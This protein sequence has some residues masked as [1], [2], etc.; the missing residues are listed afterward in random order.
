MLGRP[1]VARDVIEA[2][3]LDRELRRRF[4]R[5]VEDAARDAAADPPH[6]DAGKRTDL[7]DLPTFTIDPPSARDFD[8]AISAQV[9]DDVTRV[10]VHIADVTAHVLPGSP[11][12]REAMRRATS[13]YV[14]GAVEPML[15]EAL[16]NFACS[17]VPGEDRLAVTVEIDFRGA[18]RV[19][20]AFYR[21]VIR[22][23]KRLTYPQVDAIFAGEQRAEGRW[24]Q[25]LAAAR[26]VAQALDDR[27]QESRGALEILSGEPDFELDPR[28]HV[29]GQKQ[30]P[31]TESHRLV[32]HLMIA[33]NESVAT[34]LESQKRPT[35]YR[36][37]EAP[38]PARIE[39]L[40]K[41]LAS[42]DV[43]TPPLRELMTTAAGGRGG[44]GDL[45]PGRGARRADRAR[46]GG[47]RLAGA[48]L[49]QAGGVHA[50]QPRPRRSRVAALPALHLA[51]PPLSRR[52][53]APRAA[54][55]GRWR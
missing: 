14:P 45:A 17:L 50:G 1:D 52:R 32:E 49:A 43:P 11:V 51:D 5:L 3:M 20:T 29:I 48:A 27:R 7:R 6:A 33:A 30:E 23:D 54:G 44:G 18:D 9:V 36:V 8:D 25:P 26:A 39:H 19:R 47:V 35:L 12:D 41:Q 4:D 10:W 21:S 16:S 55:G 37:H 40:A 28:G 13:V 34:L 24:A 31:Q 38:D 53:R 2:F 46:P 42:L 15:P 22:S